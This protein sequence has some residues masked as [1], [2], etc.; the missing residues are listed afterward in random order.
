L[1]EGTLVMSRKDCRKVQILSRIREK[2]LT[3]R[4]AGELL[5][6]SYRQ[7]KRLWKR[8]LEGGE[9]AVI[10]KGRGQ[11]SNN[12]A[13]PELKQAI[14]D[15]Y[16]E[17]YT[18]FGPT[19]AVEK[20]VEEDELEAVSRETLRQWLIEARLWQ[21]HRRH[22]PYRKRREPKHH[23][24][25]LLQLDGSHHP[26][27]GEQHN[28]CCLMNL[29]DDA[30]GTTLSLMSQ[31][32]TSEAAMRVLWAWIKTYGIPMALYCDLKNVYLCDREPT[33][34]EQLEGKV[35]KTAFGLACEKLGIQII[36]AYSPQAKGRVERKHAVYQDRFVKEL[37]LRGATTIA[38]ANMILQGG[39]TAKLNNKFAHKPLAVEDFHVRL[40][41]GQDLRD[42]FCFEQSRSVAQD[43][44]VRHENHFYQLHR[45]KDS[46]PRAGGKVTVRVWLDGSVHIVY[47]GRRMPYNVF[48]P[49]KREARKAI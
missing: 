25:E 12:R 15:R 20:L 37:R 48:D 23:F 33:V 29:V 22:R 1:R 36:S 31:Q 35:P 16:R 9:K 43:W 19:L 6:I 42:I 18:G 3:V 39:F 34:E 4:R 14:L 8:Y 7:A 41:A 40:S 38:E 47:R 28:C 17:V 44:V 24:G 32:E 45:G 21:R 10:H 46:M 26:W 49:L 11:P 13:D 2:L 5:G 30:T 27:F